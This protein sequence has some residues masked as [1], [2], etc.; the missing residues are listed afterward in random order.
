VAVC[1]WYGIGYREL[2][3]LGIQR[4]DCITDWSY[5]KTGWLCGDC[6]IQPE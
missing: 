3:R 1:D 4:I 2:A 5:G 6:R